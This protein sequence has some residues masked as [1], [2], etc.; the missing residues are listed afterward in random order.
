MELKSQFRVGTDSSAATRI[1]HRLGV[2]RVLH[3][4]VKDLWIQEKVR[5]H[6]LGMSRVTSE[7]H[8]ADFADEV[9]G[10]QKDVRS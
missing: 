6:E 5:S 10:T 8:L 2:G 1:T 7:F 9:L 4:E 3:I